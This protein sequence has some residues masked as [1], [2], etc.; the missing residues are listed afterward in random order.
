MAV[1]SFRTAGM[2]DHDVLTIPDLVA[3]RAQFLVVT[4]LDDLSIR[5]CDHISYRVNNI[6]TSVLLRRF[7]NR[8]APQSVRTRDH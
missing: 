3:E 1:E 8:M 7:I 6:Y 5:G 2:P 4:D